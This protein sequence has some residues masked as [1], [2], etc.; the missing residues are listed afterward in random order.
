MGRHSFNQEHFSTS[1]IV[2]SQRL[3]AGSPAREEGF[4]CCAACWLKDLL[5]VQAS[6]LTASLQECLW[7]P[8]AG[9][10]AG[11]GRSSETRWSLRASPSACQFVRGSVVCRAGAVEAFYERCEET[12]K[13]LGAMKTWIGS[14]RCA[15]NDSS[16]SC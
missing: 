7:C 15:R 3:Q 6:W 9:S 13:G 12:V 5:Q 8:G 16:P 14:I 4:A 10:A 2:V 11:G 1:E